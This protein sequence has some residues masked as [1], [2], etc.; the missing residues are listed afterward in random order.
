M[1][2]R[3]TSDRDI[4]PGPARCALSLSFDDGLPSQL[5]VAVP[6]LDRRGLSATF[7]PQTEKLDQTRADTPPGVRERWAGIRGAGHEVGNHTRIHPCS[8]NFPWVMEFSRA[9]EDLSM[10]EMG[11]EI[12]QAQRII[13]SGLGARPKT[14]AYPCGMSFVG[15]GVGRQSYVPLVAR[16]FVVGRGFNSECAASPLRCDLACVPAISMDN[17]NVEALNAMV[18]AA[19]A[20]GHWLILA[21]HA[22]SDRPAPYTTDLGAFEGL[23]DRLVALNGAVWVDT[24][25]KIGS[26]LAR[27]RGV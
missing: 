6:V 20:E 17:K 3:V 16:E 21:G 12:E 14:F 1:D 2:K 15:R 18:D 24:V 9:L 10:D 19:M 26:Y 11:E 7:Y 25:E 4:W 23:L 22:I 27:E 5:D 13:E 8:A